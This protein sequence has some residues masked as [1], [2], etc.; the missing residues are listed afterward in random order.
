MWIGIEF[1]GSIRTPEVGRRPDGMGRHLDVAHVPTRRGW[2][3]VRS[4]RTGRWPAARDPVAIAPGAGVCP[5]L[6]GRLHGSRR[7]RLGIHSVVGRLRS[8]TPAFRLATLL[9]TPRLLSSLPDSEC[10]EVCRLHDACRNPA[11][12]VGWVECPTPSLG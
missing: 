6:P 9:N 8:V 5:G 1:P 4:S 11:S 10:S 7:V 12:R 3:W 2:D